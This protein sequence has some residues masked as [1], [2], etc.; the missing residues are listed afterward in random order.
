MPSA[1]AQAAFQQ[2]FALH[3][4]RHLAE[5]V[6]LYDQAIALDAQH[7]EAFHLRGMALFELGQF[8]TAAQSFQAAITLVPAYA[9]AL[10]GLGL[11]LAQL[12]DQK[13]AFDCYSAA[14][15]ADGRIASPYINRSLLLRN[16]GRLEEALQS[17]NIAITLQP[18]NANAHSNRGAALSELKQPAAAIASYETALQLNPNY[19]FIAGTRIFCKTIICDWTNLDRELASLLVAIDHGQPVSPPWH[20]IG[21]ADSLA[22]QRKAAEMWVAAKHPEDLALGPVQRYAGHARV[23]IGYYSA[24]F[25]NHATAYLMAE[26]FELHDRDKFE[27]TAFSFGPATGDDMQKRIAGACDHFIEVRD[28]S[29]REIAALSREMEIDIAIDLKGFSADNRIGIFAHRAAPI[30]VSY[31]GYPCTMGAPYIDYLIADNVIVPEAARPFYTEKVLTL[32]HSYQVNDRQRKISER[33]FSRAELGLPENGAVFCCFNSNFK[34]LPAMFDIWMRILK[35]VDGSVLWLLE[36]NATA[37]VNLRKEAERRGVDAARL[38]LAPRMPPEEHLARQRVADL[39][40]D[41]LPCNAHTTASDAL[42]VGLPVLTSPGESFTSRVAASLLAAMD[43]P[44]LIAA[45]LAD[46]EAL[47]IALARDPARLKTIKDKLVHNRATSPLFD[48]VSYTRAIE[49][50]FMQMV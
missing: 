17:L 21:Y 34:I 39:F 8:S 50:L 20:L 18:N 31:L 44:E 12:G 13:A 15:A 48:T 28:K 45:T 32:P 29:E 1:P 27:I 10:N 24:D 43:L 26:L 7:A 9:A 2:A 47:A 30:Q 14:I 11:A 42:W 23:R 49:A 33:A 25:H 37:V 4:Q 3:Q 22:M 41:T 16:W 6:P 40:L 38:V 35:A 19:P 46:Y 36:D 5:A